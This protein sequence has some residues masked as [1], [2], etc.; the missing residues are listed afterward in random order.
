MKKRGYPKIGD[1]FGDVAGVHQLENL[2]P[3]IG[4]RNVQHYKLL[5]GKIVVVLDQ[6]VVHADL[7]WKRPERRLCVA[8][9]LARPIRYF[10][11]IKRVELIPDEEKERV[12]RELKRI[13][14][15]DERAV[16]YIVF[17]Q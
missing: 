16:E 4:T 17:W 11:L 10:G 15:S 8:G 1:Y 7:H 3:R 2:A 5:S 6:D 12:C 9:Y 13:T 14:E